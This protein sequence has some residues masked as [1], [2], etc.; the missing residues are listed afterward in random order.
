MLPAIRQRWYKKH[1]TYLMQQVA[2][3]ESA[4][5][6]GGISGFLQKALPSLQ[7]ALGAWLAMNNLITGGMVIAAVHGDG[8]ADSRILDLASL[9][10]GATKAGADA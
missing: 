3:S 2:A 5:I 8:F 10:T 6:T 7:M 4:G 1:R 9:K